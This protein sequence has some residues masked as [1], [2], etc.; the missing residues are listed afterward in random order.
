[1]RLSQILTVRDQ[2]DETGRLLLEDSAPEMAKR[3]AERAGV[4][5][6]TETCPYRD[7]PSRLGG[8]MN[9]SAYDALRHDTAD[10]LNGLAWLTTQYGALDPSRKSTAR[11]LMDCS[12]LG[13]TL[14]LILF[15]RA[16]N[17]F[18]PHGALPSYVASIFKASRGLFSAAVDFYNKKG[19]PERS[20]S[21]AE[22]VAFAEAERHLVRPNTRRVCAAPTRL[23]DRT[24]G[25]I[26]TGE[27]A[28][29]S[30]SHIGDLV[31]FSTLWEFYTYEDSFGE[32]LSQYRFMLNRLTE[33]GAGSDPRRLFE[34]RILD[35]GDSRSF[36]EYT[37]AF[38]EQANQ[39]QT[40]LNRLL[41]RA[42]NASPVTFE[43]VLRLL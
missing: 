11:G 9:T 32:A 26:L 30:R 16:E 23:I 18:P 36:G 7:T 19:P 34:A 43:D 29:P 12:H 15:Y 4:P 38:L 28:D 31:N 20:V 2:T 5:M 41:G 35:E 24:I 33:S 17:P 21:A 13:L 8:L 10:M 37:E 40:E 27:G 42:A 22:V 39:V 6:T 3:K 1:M 14:P 25:V